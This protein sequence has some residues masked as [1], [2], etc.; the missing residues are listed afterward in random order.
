MKSFL[1][2]HPLTDRGCFHILA[3]VNN[4]SMNMEVADYLF[5]LVFFFTSDTSLEVE[6]MDCM[7]DLFVVF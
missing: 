5:K 7:V 6:L 2:I 3:I 1:S 4:A